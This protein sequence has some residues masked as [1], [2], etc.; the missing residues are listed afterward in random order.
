MGVSFVPFKLNDHFLVPEHIVMPKEKANELF[1]SLGISK[2][3]M[4]QILRTDPAIKELKL[5]KGDIIKIIRESPTAGKAVY[6][7]RVI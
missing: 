7:R 3:L 6:Y 4:P 5:K 1:D 2:D